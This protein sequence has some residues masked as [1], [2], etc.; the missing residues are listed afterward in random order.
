MK[1]I[2][3]L[4]MGIWFS[5]KGRREQIMERLSDKYR[6]I[7]F[8]KMNNLLSIIK[9]HPGQVKSYLTLHIQMVN[10]YLIYVQTPAWYFPLG[11]SI[12]LLNI[13]NNLILH[14]FVWLVKH[15][16][17]I[18]HV[19]I[20]WVGYPFAVDFVKGKKSVV[21]D[22]FDEHLGWKGYYLKRTVERIERD[23]L[24]NAEAAIFSSSK[25]FRVKGI[26][27]KKSY[28]IMNGVDY[29][30]FYMP[31]EKAI[32]FNKI[33]LYTG[34][35][36][37]WFDK[38]LMEYCANRLPDYTFWLVGPDRGNYLS[39]LKTMP[40]VKCFGFIEY[41]DLP[42][43]YHESSVCII[44][45]VI[46]DLIESTNPIKL[47]EYLAAGK[48]VVTT[49]FEEVMKYPSDVYVANDQKEFVSLIQKACLEN[50]FDK[51]ISRQHI[52][53]LNTWD[54]RVEQVEEVIQNMEE[55]E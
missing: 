4:E 49:K 3:A 52:A 50:R 46:D 31:P 16:L 40:N 55:V 7:Y 17:N 15:K 27:A 1:T 26:N 37:H 20:W 23:I 14:R 34:V 39:K 19:D 6:I 42:R 29:Q 41:K 45:F 48:P 22:C 30:H 43:Y 10:P 53:K 5:H 32:N 54:K 18:K 9:N 8:D 35:I 25:L 28:L 51:V 33:V 11:N 12:R 38:P 2:I 21:Y 13:L 36:S 44:P 47:Y 24:R